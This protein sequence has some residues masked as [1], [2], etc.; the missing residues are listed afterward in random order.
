MQNPQT[1]RIHLAD[2]TIPPRFCEAESKSFCYFLLL[3]KVESSFPL[4]TQIHQR[5]HNSV[6]SHTHESADSTI[7]SPSISLVFFRK[8]AAPRP[9]SPQLLFKC[10]PKSRRFSLLG[11]VP[12]FSVSSKKSAGGTSAPLIPDFLHHETGE[13]LV[14]RT[15]LFSI[16]F[17]GIVE[18]LV[19]WGW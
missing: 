15:T 12:R 5:F 6:E 13:F 9:R 18:S 3:Q 7:P 2:S 10:F 4:K 1:H 14:L 17:C 16:R 19:N 8:R 11:G